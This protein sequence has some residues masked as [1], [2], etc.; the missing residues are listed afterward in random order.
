MVMSLAW[1][2]KESTKYVHK[3]VLGKK[4]KK[5]NGLNLQLCAELVMLLMLLPVM[6]CI[7]SIFIIMLMDYNP[8]KSMKKTGLAPK[9]W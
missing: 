8:L 1:E 4:F 2:K 3:K 6:A 9:P 7:N 5:K